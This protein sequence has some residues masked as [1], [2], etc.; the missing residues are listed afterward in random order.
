MPRA[1][2][3]GASASPLASGRPGSNRKRHS[4]FAGFYSPSCRRDE[5][6]YWAARLQ[7]RV[8][9]SR[10]TRLHVTVACFAC[11]ACSRTSAIASTVRATAPQTR[12]RTRQ[13]LVQ[14]LVHLTA[15]E[16]LSV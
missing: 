11:F 12:D 9:P 3:K 13:D 2:N 14:D 6:D 16:R 8:V 7:R 15:P 5:R 10:K 4:N 1:A